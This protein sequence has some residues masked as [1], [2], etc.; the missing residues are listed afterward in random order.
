MIAKVFATS[1]LV[2]GLSMGAHAQGQPETF[3]KVKVGL[4]DTEI[5]KME[6]GIP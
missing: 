6:H 5:Q 1:V 4:P 3:F 2:A